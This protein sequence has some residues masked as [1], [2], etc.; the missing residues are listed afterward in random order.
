MIPGIVL[1]KVFQALEEEFPGIHFLVVSVVRWE[2]SPDAYVMRVELRPTRADAVF[3]LFRTMTHAERI[4]VERAP[5]GDRRLGDVWAQWAREYARAA[6]HPI[7]EAN[8]QG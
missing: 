6:Y 3:A 1:Q 7:A 4:Q 2:D 5:L 8:Q